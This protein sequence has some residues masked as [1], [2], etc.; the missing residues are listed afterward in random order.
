MKFSFSSKK[1]AARNVDP[2]MGEAMSQRASNPYLEARREW[3]ER[4]GSYIA[5]KRN[6]QVVAFMSLG[7]AAVAVVGNVYQAGQTKVRTY[8]VETN[9][10]GEPMKVTSADQA[11]V[12]DPRYVAAQLEM[13]I[14]NTRSV[15]TDPAVQ[16]QW[17]DD[18]YA[19]AGP[20][21]SQVLNDY[22][23]QPQNDPWNR[24]KSETVQVVLAPATPLPGG[25]SWQIEWEETRTSLTGQLIGKS[26]YQA[27]ITAGHIE[28]QEQD[29]FMKNL[30]GT[31]AETLAWNPRL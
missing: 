5:Q 20:V 29:K 18:A 7:I 10:M 11:A 3:T 16:K 28:Q 6:W 19:M 25:K 26:R 24:M 27:I 8:I 22:F 4:Y 1:E 30:S 23:R 15:T 14:H 2:V 17:L 31:I 9:K 12:V 21:T 13:F